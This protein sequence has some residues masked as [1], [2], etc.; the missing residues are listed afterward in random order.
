MLNICTGLATDITV[1]NALAVLECLRITVSVD[2]LLKHL[3]FIYVFS[4]VDTKS[5]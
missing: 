1:P 3:K 5:N 2:K 4:S